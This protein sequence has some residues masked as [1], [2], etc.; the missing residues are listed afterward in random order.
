MPSLEKCD[1][2]YCIFMKI[3][4]L[5]FGEPG[6][7]KVIHWAQDILSAKIYTIFDYDFDS[8]DEWEVEPNEPSIDSESEKEIHPMIM[9]FVDEVFVV[10]DGFLMSD[11][12]FPDCG[13]KT[14]KPSA[15]QKPFRVL[16]IKPTLNLKPKHFSVLQLYAAEEFFD[17]LPIKTVSSK[18]NW[19]NGE[20]PMADKALCSNTPKKIVSKEW[21]CDNGESPM[22]DGV[23]RSGNKSSMW[24]VNDNDVPALIRM[25]HGTFQNKE[26][27]AKDF[28]LHL[29]PNRAEE[30]KDGP[31]QVQ[32]L[33]E[34]NEIASW[35]KYV[36]ACHGLAGLSANLN[37][38][39]CT[40]MKK[41]GRKADDSRSEEDTPPA[42]TARMSLSSK[43]V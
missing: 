19:K 27:I 33:L 13:P 38:E 7:N 4:D 3:V 6:L 21:N 15:A 10:P 16:E 31:S 24:L 37:W 11:D 23:T 8:N 18:L 2:S 42:K 1:R 40:E 35:R 30:S 34:I 26:K 25:L 41:R 32:I 12:E 29:E 5:L 20:S 28:K 22:A 17:S 14:A 36:L 39:L 43:L 9:R